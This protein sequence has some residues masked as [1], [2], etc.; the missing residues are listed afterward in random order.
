MALKRLIAV[1][2]MSLLALKPVIM[3]SQDAIINR[4]AVS[5]TDITKRN[6]FKVEDA[7]LV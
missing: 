7:K 5:Q 2:L 3:R 4:L 1:Q 6:A